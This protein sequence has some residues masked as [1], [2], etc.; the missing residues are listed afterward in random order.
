MNTKHLVSVI[1]T[2]KNNHATLEACLSSIVRQTYQPLELIVVDNHSRD[3]TP[4]IARRYTTHIYTRG[5]ERSA[6]RNFGVRKAQGD[7]VLIIDSDMELDEQVVAACVEWVRTEPGAQALI[8]PE[9]SFGRGFWAQCKR[10]E[11][12]FYVGQDA[13]EAARFFAKDLYTRVQGY[14]E[15]LTG[16]EDWDLTNRVREHTTVGRIAPFIFHNEGH[17][18]FSR[19]LHK[20]YYYGRHAQA[21]FAANPGASALTSQSGPLARYMLFFSKPHTLLAQPFT[22]AGMLLLKTGE[23]AAASA[24][25]LTERLRPHRITKKE[26]A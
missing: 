7:Y 2:T 10:L 19:T 6:Q 11:R 16:G 14:N 25:M 20:M 26:S 1:V 18:R 17:P 9:E 22:A 12:S 23:Y 3:D 13:I 15:A 21:Y 4:D 8:I 5:P 24:G